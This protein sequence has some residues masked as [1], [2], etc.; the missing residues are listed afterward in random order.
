MDGVP[1]TAP[2][3]VLKL[4]PGGRPVSDHDEMVPPPTTE[5]LGVREV[6]AV[7]EVEVWV[8]GLVTVTTSLIVHA[9]LLLVPEK[10]A[11]SVA[12]AVTE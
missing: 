10:P 6:M 4:S 2:V 8:P 9:K 12:V 11:E 5:A 7:P 1:E 3:V